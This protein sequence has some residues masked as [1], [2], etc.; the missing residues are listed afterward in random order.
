V[1][2]WISWTKQSFFQ[3]IFTVPFSFMNDDD[4]I[5]ITHSTKSAHRFG[6][7]QLGVRSNVL[8]FAD[9]TLFREYID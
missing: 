8:I 1:L 3:K 2:F 4:T 5:P 6:V 9:S 7:K